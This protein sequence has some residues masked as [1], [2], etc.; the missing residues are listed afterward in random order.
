MTTRTISIKLVIKG[1]EQY[2]QA[3][4][5]CNTDLGVMRSELADS[6]SELGKTLEN[7]AGQSFKKFIAG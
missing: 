5:N 7:T 6:G 1:K 3:L 2:R 4:R